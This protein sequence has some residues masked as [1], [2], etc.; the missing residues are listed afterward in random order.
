MIKAYNLGVRYTLGMREPRK[1][2]PH[3][4]PEH[5]NPPPHATEKIIPPFPTHTPQKLNHQKYTHFTG[6]LRA[7][8]AVG[9]GGERCFELG[10]GRV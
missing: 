10:W 6:S 4:K 1:I 8:V 9:R 5:H 2:Y 3:S 7:V